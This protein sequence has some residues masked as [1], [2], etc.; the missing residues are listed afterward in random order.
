VSEYLGPVF[1]IRRVPAGFWGFMKDLQN[2]FEFLSGT[3]L[4]QN[5]KNKNV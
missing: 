4:K 1:S 2:K 3:G 5:E